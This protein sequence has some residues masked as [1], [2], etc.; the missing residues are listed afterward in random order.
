MHHGVKGQQWGVKNGP[1]YP[2]EN[3]A[4]KLASGINSKAQVKEVK[5]TK[6]VTSAVKKAGGKMYGLENKL[7]TKESISRKIRTDS[8]EKNISFDESAK[9][10]KDAVRYTMISDDKNFVSDYEK[11]KKDLESKGYKEE[12]CKNYFTLYKEGKAKHKSVQSVFSDK[13]GYKFEMQFQTPQ[14]QK[15]KDEKIPIYEERRKPGNTAKRNM[16][17]EWQ[18]EE[19]AEKVPD[20]VGIEKIKSH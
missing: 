10:I 15:A 8:E 16:E 11:V 14:S 12:R 19:L 20:P 18:M 9:D 4:K 17:L 13:T 1:P 3:S 5:I 7:K 6:D 2:L